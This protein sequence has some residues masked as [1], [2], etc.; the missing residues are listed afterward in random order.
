MTRNVLLVPGV[1]TV[2]SHVHARMELTVMRP[3]ATVTVLGDLLVCTVPRDVLKEG[4]AITV[5]ACVSATMRH[6]S[7]VVLMDSAN[8]ILVTMV[9]IVNISV[10]RTSMGFIVYTTVL[11]VKMAQHHV[12]TEQENAI[13]KPAGKVSP[14]T[15]SVMREHGERTV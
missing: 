2:Q 5:K 14:V 6:L 15:P 1:L 7:A 13:V 3:Q 9:T 4:M 12:I 11:A 10:H 8:V